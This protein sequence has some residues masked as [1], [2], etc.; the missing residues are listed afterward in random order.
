MQEPCQCLHAIV[1]IAPVPFGRYDFGS[2]GLQE[3]LTQQL[4]ASRRDRYR[5]ETYLYV[6]YAHDFASGRLTGLSW[7]CDNV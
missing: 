3:A 1:I 4:I 6:P 7:D 2:I 5:L